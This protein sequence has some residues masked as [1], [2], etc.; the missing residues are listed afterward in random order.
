[1]KMKKIVST[2]TI[3]FIL[4]SCNEKK[5]EVIKTNETIE[6]KTISEKEISLTEFL[7]N[8]N[9]NNNVSLLGWIAYYKEFIDKDFDIS[10]FD[11]NDGETITPKKSSVYA[12]F[13]ENFDKTYLPFLIYAPN[14][15]HYIDIDSNYWTVEDKSKTAIFEDGQA[16]NLVNVETKS[17]KTLFYNSLECY[18]EDAF[19]INN[20]TIAF[21]E[22]FNIEESGTFNP[23][24]IIVD[25]NTN[26]MKTFIYDKNVGKV[27]MYFD[28]R[29]RKKGINVPGE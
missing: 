8:E 26:K 10:N 2:A 14:K 3:V 21:L 28:E 11:F 24:I 6:S 20:T 4:F 27:S 17:S 29:L 1:M 25:T 16:I 9:A 15:K 23:R 12:V 22:S 19:W 13:D 5:N 18:V 7:L